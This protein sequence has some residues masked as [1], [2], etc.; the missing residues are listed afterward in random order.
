MAN[1]PP[2]LDEL[3]NVKQDTVQWPAKAHRVLSVDENG[4]EHNTDNPTPIGGKVQI[5]NGVDDVDV[6]ENLDDNTDLQ[7]AIGLINNAIMYGRVSGSM[8]K[9]LRIDAVTHAMT[10]VEYSHH[11]KHD[12]RNYTKT[13]V[14]NGTSLII[15]FKV[16]DQARQPHIVLKWN[17]EETAI[18]NWWKGATWTPGTGTT[19]I[20]KNSND[21]SGNTSILQSDSS[22]SFISN[23]VVLDPTGF[24]SAA[25]TSIYTEAIWGTNQSPPSSG[26][27]TREE[28]IAAP[29]ETYGIEITASNG[30]M[31]IYLDWYEHTPKD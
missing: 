7:N 4:D 15:A 24:S 26:E 17:A 23:G 31:W 12:G 16:E 25:A 14:K 19:L 28:H 3:N 13:Y 6:A 22:G 29:A 11:E 10:V 18:I 21:N 27:G 20:P 1:R 9:P 2:E 8:I 5:T 30:G